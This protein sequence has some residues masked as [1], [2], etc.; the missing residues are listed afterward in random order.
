MMLSFLGRVIRRYL[1]LTHRT[2]Y[3]IMNINSPYSGDATQLR[4]WRGVSRTV[5]GYI[6]A[7][8]G[9]FQC[10]Y[11]PA[12]TNRTGT[13]S[14]MLPTHNPEFVHSLPAPRAWLS[15]SDGP[16]VPGP[17]I[18]AYLVTLASADR[19]PRALPD[20]I[21]PQYPQRATRNASGVTRLKRLA[22]ATGAWGSWFSGEPSS[23]CVVGGLETRPPLL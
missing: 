13:T 20:A 2:Q 14:L 12:S 9:P 6:P 10:T 11:I 5:L 7:L 16:E 8:I 18:A 22:V 19:K 21:L 23:S 15:A 3:L 17:D 1:Q 4:R